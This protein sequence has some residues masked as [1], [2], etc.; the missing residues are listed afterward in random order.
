MA[1]VF[2]IYSPSLD[3]QF[4]LDDHHYVG[5]PRL[6]TS[7]HIWEYFTTYVWAQITGGPSSFYRP[8]FVLWL[9]IN[10]IFFEMSPEGWHLF[11]VVKHLLVVVL[12]GLLVWKFLRDRTAVLLAMSLFAVHPSHTES[13]AWISVPDPLMAAGVLISL[14][15]YF[16]FTDSLVIANQSRGK[17]SRKVDRTNRAAWLWLVASAFCCFLGL[18]LKETGII[19]LVVT[20]VLAFAMP[21]GGTGAESTFQSRVLTALRVS[22]P[23]LAVTVTYFLLR[24]N[25]LGETVA[26][27]QHL[28]WRTVVLSWPATLWFYVKV[29][30]WPVRLRA[31]ADSTQ[32]DTLSLDGVILPA[33]GLSCA[34]GLLVW[35]FYWA[36]KRA[37]RDLS[38]SEAT[39]VHRALIVGALLLVLPLLLTLNLNSLVPAD[40]LHGRYAYLSTAGL[41]LLLATAWRLATK[42]RVALLFAAGLLTI[43]FAVFTLKQEGTW[44]DDLSVFTEAHEV[45]PHNAPV[46]L[47]LARA[48]VQVALHLGESGRCQEAMPLLDEV[49][50]NYPQDWYAWAAR[51]DCQV[52]LSQLQGAEQSLHRAAEL[53][54]NPRVTD[55]WQQ[56][57]GQLYGLS[58][59][60]QR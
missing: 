39:G 52:Q 55:Q 33:L 7:G 46:A 17:K 13:V 11:S 29:L 1:A 32:A 28:P 6:Q 5:D 26:L 56:V 44:K 60:A 16:K 57:R 19:L 50:Q 37:H 48:H 45:A 3:Y 12:L 35:L 18:L 47:S 54:H 23:F 15:L 53:S 43:A 20:C 40:F 9:R 41:M 34:V 21:P 8:L 10:Y 42:Y 58:S 59:G 2:A 49:I 51:G 25:T 24:R 22:V 36:W 14:L 30:L 27:T 31:F 38:E 4:I